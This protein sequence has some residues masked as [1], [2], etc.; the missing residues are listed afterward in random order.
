[1]HNARSERC[2]WIAL[3]CKRHGYEAHI[4]LPSGLSSL[5]IKIDLRQ[6]FAEEKI[7]DQFAIKNGVARDIQ[8]RPE[9][10]LSALLDHTD[11]GL[12][13]EVSTLFRGE[14]ALEIRQE[15][16]CNE[17]PV[18]TISDAVGCLV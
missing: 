17:S 2:S 9:G 6:I 16:L 3:H 5:P 10:Y 7:D 15:R 11:A 1:M 8:E 12:D 14:I 18:G 4:P 13:Q